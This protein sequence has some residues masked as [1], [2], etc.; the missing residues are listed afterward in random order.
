M[1]VFSMKKLKRL[2]DNKITDL[3]RN[4]YYKKCEKNVNKRYKLIKKLNALSLED[5]R[6]TYERLLSEFNVLH[7][8]YKVLW[9]KK[10][11]CSWK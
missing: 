3:R 10:A 2:V 6:E 5:N 11:K 8:K 1:E 7:E 9:D 4:Y